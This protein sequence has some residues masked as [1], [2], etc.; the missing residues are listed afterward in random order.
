M[1]PLRESTKD[2][3]RLVFCLAA[4]MTMALL[5]ILTLC[6]RLPQALAVLR[7]MEEADVHA[8]GDF[9]GDRATVSIPKDWRAEDGPHLYIT[10]DTQMLCNPVD[11]E[12]RL[13]DIKKLRRRA[14]WGQPRP[15]PPP[16]A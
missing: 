16:P 7:A 8:E 15:P 1:L 2:W 5:V 9:S 10:E 12:W 3:P 4:T 13:L 11:G 6:D 14:E